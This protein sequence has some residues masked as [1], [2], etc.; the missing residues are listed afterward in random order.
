[1]TRKGSEVRV[2]YGH[3]LCGHTL[4]PTDVVDVTTSPLVRRG[5]EREPEG[6]FPFTINEEEAVCARDGLGEAPQV[7]TPSPQRAGAAFRELPIR[8]GIALREALKSQVVSQIHAKGINRHHEWVR[9][10]V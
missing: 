10:A 2:L 5:F 3:T 9:L 6:V 4:R 1:M 8:V 7:C